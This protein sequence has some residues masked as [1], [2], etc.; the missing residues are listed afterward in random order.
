[1]EQAVE[2]LEKR[3]KGK[4]VIDEELLKSELLTY[5]DF[6]DSYKFR[7]YLALSS[8]KDYEFYKNIY[9]QRVLGFDDNILKEMVS[10]NKFSMD[11]LF[12]FRNAAER[13][14]DAALLDQVVAKSHI[15]GDDAIRVEE[16]I[17]SNK[18]QIEKKSKFLADA[19]KKYDGKDEKDIEQLVYDARELDENMDFG[20]EEKVMRLYLQQTEKGVKKYNYR[21]D[22]WEHLTHSVLAQGRI[23]D[24]KAELKN[25]QDDRSLSLQDSMRFKKELLKFK[26]DFNEDQK[27]MQEDKI[28]ALQQLVYEK[29]VETYSEHNQCADEAAGRL[30]LINNFKLPDDKNELQLFKLVYA[31]YNIGYFDEAR[32][33]AK[34]LQEKYPKGSLAPSIVNLVKYMPQ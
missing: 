14:G 18:Q 26:N 32:K 17:V 21:Y 19:K 15:F 34:V 27:T 4:T 12:S 3:E 16:Q 30:Q 9:V 28:A 22:A 33:A 5:V 23:E 31:Y 11:E 7:N 20:F 13:F 10:D 2:E 29:K 24:A 6:F 25:Y 1:M 8:K